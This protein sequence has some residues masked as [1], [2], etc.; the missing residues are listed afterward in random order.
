MKNYKIAGNIFFWIPLIGILLYLLFQSNYY[1]NNKKDID[2]ALL[3]LIS[4]HQ[5]LGVLLSGIYYDTDYT[6]ETYFQT[7]H[8]PKLV[9]ILRFTSVVMWII[10]LLYKIDRWFFKHLTI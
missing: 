3:I 4:I 9:V 2:I 8:S 1:V 7:K 5:G 10:Y 6:L